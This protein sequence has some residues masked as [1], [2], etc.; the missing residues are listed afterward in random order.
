MYKSIRY[1]LYIAFWNSF[2]FAVDFIETVLGKRNKLTPPSVLIRSI[3]IHKPKRFE[4]LSDKTLNDIKKLVKLCPNESILD[5][6]CGVGRLAI[7]LLTYLDINGR[8]EGVDVDRKKINWCKNH[9]TSRNTNFRFHNIDVYD[10]FCNPKGRQ[11][12]SEYTFAYKSNTFSF[13]CLLS[14]FTHMLP[15]GVSR[16]IEEIYRM[17]RVGGRVL[18]T[19]FLLNNN[20]KC[21][22][23]E[24]KI[25]PRFDFNYGNY[26]LDDAKYPQK[27]VAYE[28]KYISELLAKHRLRIQQPIHT[29][30]WC[31]GTNLINRQ[32]IIVAAKE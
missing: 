3:G 28:E 31:G 5:I 24:R 30:Y 11:K 10:Q 14:V 29:G 20:S 21:L 6:G 22:I 1:T 9:I 32:D 7:P 12:T 25:F 13:I 4:K 27:F 8:Y 17:L 16:Y 26:A 18:M 2:Y 15:D 19:F 23:A